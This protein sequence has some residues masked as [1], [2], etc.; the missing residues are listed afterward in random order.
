MAI[1]NIDSYEDNIQ[2]ENNFADDP[3][4]YIVPA[5]FPGKT[6]GIPLRKCSF[7]VTLAS[8][9]TGEDI[10][11]GFIPKGATIFGGTHVASATLA[12]TGNTAI[13]LKGADESGY[14][15]SANSVS[16]GDALLK[17]AA[18]L[19]TTLVTFGTTNALKYGYVAQKDLYLTMTITTASSTVATEV[20]TGWYDI[21]LKG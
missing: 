21:L 3:S 11:I 10:L 18:A 8:Q 9:A 16:D 14:I 13:G 17:V 7:T 4:S 1:T 6:S 20:I 5:S 15:D 19:S 12:N 2:A